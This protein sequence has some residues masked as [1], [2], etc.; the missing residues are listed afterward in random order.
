MSP[1]LKTREADKRKAG[2][3]LVPLCL[4]SRSVAAI[5]ADFAQ[6]KVELAKW[7]RVRR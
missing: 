6:K 7:I 3:H 1:T 4:R 5:V 2:R